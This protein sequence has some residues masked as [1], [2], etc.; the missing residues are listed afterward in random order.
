MDLLSSPINDPSFKKRR[1]CS[2]A[3]SEHLQLQYGAQSQS[4]FHVLKLEGEIISDNA[5]NQVNK[6]RAFQLHRPRSPVICNVIYICFHLLSIVSVWRTNHQSTKSHIW[7][8]E[9]RKTGARNPA[10][11]TYCHDRGIWP[12]RTSRGVKAPGR[13]ISFRNIM[14][15]TLSKFLCIVR[16]MLKIVRMIILFGLPSCVQ[17]HAKM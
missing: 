16:K 6:T 5:A 17:T 13:W 14:P 2:S 3:D 9:H 4:V 8:G 1:L 10:C 12:K 15:S 7:R 11:A